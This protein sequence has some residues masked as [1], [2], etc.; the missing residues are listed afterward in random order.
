MIERLDK[1]AVRRI[2]TPGTLVSVA[3]IGVRSELRGSQV[4]ALFE[5]WS[6]PACRITMRRS[7]QIPLPQPGGQ[8][9]ILAVRLDGIYRLPAQVEQLEI[10]CSPADGCDRCL[11]EA[12]PDQARAVRQQKRRFFRLT[13]DWPVTVAITQGEPGDYRN[14]VFLTRARNLGADG[15]LVEDPLEALGP[16]LRFGLTLDLGDGEGPLEMTAET[17]R[18]DER[19]GEPGGRWGCRLL[20][21]T[22]GQET[23][24]LRHLNDRIRARLG[25]QMVSVEG[26]ASARSA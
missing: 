15:I 1:R 25:G 5:G 16:G 3:E 14:R 10:H 19:T 13:G 12:R 23:R 6:G 4:A 2:F 7:T 9:E 22:P 20:E 8:I 11:I 17:V 24:I 26:A 18:R 21:L